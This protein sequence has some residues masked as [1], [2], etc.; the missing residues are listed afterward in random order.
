MDLKDRS[1]VLI[2]AGMHR[3]GTSLTASLLQS[4]GLHIGRKLLGADHVNVKGHFENLDFYDFHRE[5]LRSQGVNEDGWTLQ[6]KIEVE[7]RFLEEAKA[8]IAKSSISKE[9]GWK[10]PRTTL[11]LDFW[12]NLL[13]EAKFLLIYR[14]PWEVVDSLYRRGDSIFQSQPDFAVKIWMHYNRK[15][16]ELYNRFTDRCF[17]VNLHTLVN[18]FER[19][20]SA[21]NQK[22]QLH[23]SIPTS[24]L[25]DPS[26]LKAHPLEGHRAS[27][28]SHYFP[29]AVEMYRELESRAWQHNDRVD[30]SELDQL[31][32]SPFRVWAFQDWVQVGRLQGE[33]YSSQKELEQLRSQHQQIQ[34]ELEESRSQHQ[35]T[36]TEL[37]QSRSQVQQTQAELEQSRS[38]VQ[39]TQAELEQSRSQ[40]QQ[41]QTELEQSRSQV[42]QTQAELE[43]SRS[44]VQQ[45]QA[46]LEQSRS[47][48]QQTQAELEQSRSQV[49]QTQTEL[50]QSQFYLKQTQG[51]LEQSQFQ[52]QQTQIELE[53]SVSQL[54]Q[55]QEELEQ[56]QI[57]LLNTKSQLQQ[58]KGEQKRSQSQLYQI[59]RELDQT[60]AQ[61]QSTKLMLDQSQVKVRQ[62]EEQLHKSLAKLEEQLLESVAESK[63]QLRESEAKF[64]TEQEKLQSELY[65][66]KQELKRSQSILLQTQIELEQSQRQLN[67]TQ[68]EFGQ[69]R[70][71]Q[72]LANSP[73]TEEQFDY[74]LLVWKAWSAYRLGDLA[75]M[76]ELLRQSWQCRPYSR[77]ETILNWLDSFT[78]FS[79]ENGISL[80]IEVLTSSPEWQKLVRRITLFKPTRQKN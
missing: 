49:Q 11:F 10:E 52:L 67:Q 76:T 50:E 70:L 78:I 74:R 39:Q 7:D 17:L 4:A 80:N 21:I 71:E 38:Q 3:S 25:Y 48:V 59:Q 54:N 56:I 55:T 58:S 18:H 41:T 1:S 9:W 32:S 16:L 37:E 15:V 5:V 23:L 28:V 46:E 29:E 43:Q 47:Q 2:I 35:Q 26:R 13:P 69:L 27:L 31:Q 20:I 19:F 53:N 30:F 57:E 8:L 45:T 51:E 12:A 64:K 36:Q 22:L 62:K 65:Q 24:T 34:T 66:T 63:T 75:K 73:D 61:L 72:A 14:Y 44:Q 6:E 68:Q 33:K 42:Q 79:D 60:Q 40:V 77:S